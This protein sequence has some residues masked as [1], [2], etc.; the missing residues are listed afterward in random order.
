MK[1][2]CQVFEKAGETGGKR[3]FVQINY[4]TKEFKETP[5]VGSGKNVCKTR[6]MGMW[7]VIKGRT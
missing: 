3:A 5:N 1:F 7:R 4:A 2:L 6:V